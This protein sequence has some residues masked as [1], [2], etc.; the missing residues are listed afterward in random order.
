MKA[1]VIHEFGSTPRYEDFPDPKPDP[2]GILVRV[3]ATALEN[4]DRMTAKGTHYSSRETY[5]G[6]PAIVGHAGVGTLADGSLVMFGGVSPPYGTMAEM[7]MV[8]QKYKMY[9]SPVPSGVDPAV[10]AAA[11]SSIL[12]SLLSLKFGAKLQ[13]GE[14]VLVNGATGF[15]G[16]L[17][18]QIAKML[19]ARR[20]TGAGRDEESL[21]RLPELGADAVIDLKKPDGLISRDFE[22][23]AG[24]G[25]D[26]V[27]DFLWG[28]PT[29]LLLKTFVPKEAGF[30]THRTRFVQIG[31]AAGPVISLAAETL[32]TSGLEVSGAGAISPSVI[33]EALNQGWE[34]IK[35]SKLQIDVEKVP[36]KDIA[37]AWNRDAHGK[38]I[39][40]VP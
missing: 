8:P 14:T 10:A 25:Y 30:P 9:M 1:G 12:T 37:E 18:V 32:R 38:R 3:K 26:V 22:Q 39:V 35:E 15:A 34:W 2:D 5:P 17:A 31:E 33:P 20:V 13:P 40:I 21:R 29:E 27:V 23:D 6:F 19:G 4:F 7:A 28:R 11:P 24:D 16:K 36:L